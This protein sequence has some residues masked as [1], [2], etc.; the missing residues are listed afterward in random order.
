M[1]DPITAVMGG[2]QLASGVASFAG[3]SKAANESNAA[4][5][6]NYKLAKNHRD[7]VVKYN[8][9]VHASNVRMNLRRQREE[10]MAARFRQ[11]STKKQAMQAKSTWRAATADRGLT[12]RSIEAVDNDLSRQEGDA[13]SMISTN[14]RSVL[15]QL[16][17][18]VDGMA[19]APVAPV[20]APNFT[21]GPSP[22]SLVGTVVNTGANMVQMD[23]ML[24]GNTV[25]QT[26][27]R[28][29]GT[30]KSALMI[31][32]SP[33]GATKGVPNSTLQAQGLY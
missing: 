13:V 4:A 24:T 19:P 8:Q 18:E 14:L 12:G 3:A 1:C 7:N 6:Q 16:R 25:K 22:M 5:M 33:A 20:G 26:V 15:G 27:S 11:E 21:E 29:S 17:A 2:L 10:E 28:A 30:A 32:S 23:G 31:G 9:R